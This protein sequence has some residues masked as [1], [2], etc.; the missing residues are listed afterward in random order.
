MTSNELGIGIPIPIGT[1]KAGYYGCSSCEWS[2]IGCVTCQTT[3]YISPPPKPMPPGQVNGIFTP[4]KKLLG[5]FEIVSDARQS[6]KDG[7]GLIAKRFIPRSEKFVDNT[8]PYICKPAEYAKAHLGAE[9]YVA[10]GTQ[11]YFQ[12]REPV[13]Q[14]SI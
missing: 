5:A 8:A 2:P 6:D 13:L 4:S 11:G 1:R 3:N 9:D 14:V 12:V 7:F 10:C